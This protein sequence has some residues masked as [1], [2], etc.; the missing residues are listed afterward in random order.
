MASIADSIGIRTP[1]RDA[2][3]GTPRALG[4]DRWIFVAM[5]AWYIVI[6]LVGFIPDSIMKIEQVHAGARPDFPFALHLH[7]V[8]MGAF[9]CV[10]LA[11]SWLVAIGRHDYHVRL[12]VAGFG[13]AVAVVAGA[14]F[15]LVTRYHLAAEALEAASSQARGELMATLARMDRI[16]ARQIT[17]CLL[18]SLLMGIAFRARAYDPSLHK[19]LIFLAVA[20]PLSAA[21]GRMTWL[22]HTREANTITADIYTLATI[23]P[24]FVWDVVRNRRVH[25][26]YWIWLGAFVPAE[27]TVNL[28]RDTPWWH[29]AARQIMGI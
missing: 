27:V 16:L 12:G 17:T 18:F 20:I 6:V 21:T 7:A 8:L 22:L 25:K 15:L 11:Q 1:A 10:L 26:A 13:L 5:S 29:A 9:L 3:S 2:L 28:V 23:A 14:V 24:L 19:R 4:L